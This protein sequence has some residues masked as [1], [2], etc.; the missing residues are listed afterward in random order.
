MQAWLLITLALSLISFPLGAADNLQASPKFDV[1]IDCA[2]PKDCYIQSYVDLDPSEGAVDYQCGV[3]T[4]DGHKGTDFRLRKMSMLDTGVRVL[5]AAPGRVIRTRNDMP[6][7]HMKVFG[8][9]VL[10]RFGAGNAVVIDHGNKWVTL[11]AHLKKGSIRVRPG[12]IVKTGQTLGLVG[13]SGLTE[14]PHLHFQISH[15]NRIVDA[16]VGDH[17]STGCKSDRQPMWTAAALKRI[18]YQRSF[19]MEAGFSDQPLNREMLLFGIGV[20]KQLPQRA[21]SLVFNIDFAG[22]R[23]GD[24]YEYRILDPDGKIFA[25]SRKT[26][27]K[28]A[29]VRFLYIGKKRAK[30]PAW[31]TGIYKGQFTLMRPSEGK[32]R[33]FVRHESTLTVR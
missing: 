26:S 14:F 28:N 12:D 18:G 23:K 7:T 6:D 25:E 27:E 30:R 24:V 8:R 20:K 5:A 13:L 33:V 11:Y 15:R 3:H 32:M 2:L 9:K 1:P 4:Y 17:P 21:P 19:I 31:P 22:L 10:S 29:A 16:F